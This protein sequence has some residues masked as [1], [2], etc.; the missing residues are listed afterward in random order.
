[1]YTTQACVLTD[2]KNTRW[3]K[4]LIVEQLSFYL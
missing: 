2:Q 4:L 3:Q 1:M